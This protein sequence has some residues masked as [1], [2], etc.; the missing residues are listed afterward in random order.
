MIKQRMPYDATR[1]GQDTLDDV[2][3]AFVRHCVEDTYGAQFAEHLTAQLT[4]RHRRLTLVGKGGPER[5]TVDFDLEF[6]GPCGADVWAPPET[7]VVEVKSPDGRGIGDR[8]LRAAGARR[9]ACSKYCVGLNLIRP[10]LR[11]NVFKHLLETHF[12]WASR[13][14]EVPRASAL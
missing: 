5:F 8:A 13:P 12:G 1:H 10:G 2:S 14:V 9:A 3:T 4:I 11:Y 7:L 6:A